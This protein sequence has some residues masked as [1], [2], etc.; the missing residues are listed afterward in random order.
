[1]S[2]QEQPKQAHKVGVIGFEDLGGG[3][4]FVIKELRE[5]GPVIIS[6]DENFFELVRECNR[7]QMY[8][9]VEVPR[10]IRRRIKERTGIE[11]R[12]KVMY[13]PAQVNE[14]PTNG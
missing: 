8:F 3:K 6:W 14:Q 1:M 4:S 9:T 5:E 2:E 12:A 10:A 7:K 13:A 11:I